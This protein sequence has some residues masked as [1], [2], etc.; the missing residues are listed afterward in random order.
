MADNT[1]PSWISFRS[2]FVSMLK[3]A[4]GAT[5]STCQLSIL[6]FI[7]AEN[8]EIEIPSL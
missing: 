1:I 8:I 3:K 6:G 2:K 7:D 4:F 5:F